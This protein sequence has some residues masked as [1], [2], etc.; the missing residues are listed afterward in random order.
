MSLNGTSVHNSPP[1][2]PQFNFTRNEYETTIPIASAGDL[3]SATSVELA[4]LV[5]SSFKCPSSAIPLKMNKN[6]FYISLSKI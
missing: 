4:K 1:K 2:L 5:S 6:V 3:P